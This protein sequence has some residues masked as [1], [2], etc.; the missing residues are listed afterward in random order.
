[1]SNWGS[2]VCRVATFSA[3]AV[4]SGREIHTPEASSAPQPEKLL[5]ELECLAVHASGAPAKDEGRLDAAKGFCVYESRNDVDKVPSLIRRFESK[6]SMTPAAFTPICAQ[7][8]DA[9][10]EEG[11]K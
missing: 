3:V 11:A 8:W 10:I 6:R 2:A 7:N 4:L 5:D 9:T 1:M